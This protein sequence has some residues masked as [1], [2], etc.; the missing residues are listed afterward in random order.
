MTCRWRSSTRSSSGAPPTWSWR[1]ISRAGSLHEALA[2]A[3]LQLRRGQATITS[4]GATTDDARLLGV[5][6][7]EPLLVERRVIADVAGRPVEATESRYPGDRYALD[8]RFDVDDGTPDDRQPG[9]R[10]V[11]GSSRE[12]VRAALDHREP[13]RIPFD[14]GGS[15]MTGIHVRAYTRLRAALGLP[16]GDV[17]VG[18]LTQQLADVDT[19]VMDLLGCDVRLVGPR[20]RP[21]VPARGGGGGRLPAPSATSGASGAGCRST[22]GSTTTRSA[23]PLGR[24]GRRGDDRRLRRGRTRP[25][26]AGTRAWLEAARQIAEVEGRAVLVGSICG[27]LSE[28]LFKM[29]GFEDGYMDLAAEPERAR[30]VMEKILEVKLAYWERALREL[31]DLVDV[32]GEADDLGGQDRTLFSPATYRALVKPLQRELF[33]FIQARTSAPGSSS[34]AAARS[35]SLIPD[36]IEIGVDILNPVQ[37]SAAGMDGAEL[38]REFGRDLVFWGG[39]VD[40][41]RVLGGGNADEVRGRGPAAGRRPARAAAASCSRP[42]TTSSPTCRAENILAMWACAQGG[43]RCVRSSRDASSSRTT[44]FPVA[45]SSTTAGSRTW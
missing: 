27:G 36:L 45:W 39:G 24:R 31:G 19:D 21:G 18:D 40:T 16:P 44:W 8:V 22:A 29:R 38:K 37:V 43:Q 6:E 25:T 11:T 26:P 32:V 10:S 3:G 35:A 41:Q 5:R 20:P 1:P 30:Q 4:E 2:R 13:D 7:G 42:S 14:L 9:R 34:T 28:G 23:Q 12:R 15:R 33:A 17:R